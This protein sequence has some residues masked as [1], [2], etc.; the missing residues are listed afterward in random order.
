MSRASRLKRFLL[1][2]QTAWSIV[3][4]TLLLILAVELSL[5]GC[6]WL[7]DLRGP[8][9]PPD[10]RLVAEGY[11]GATWPATHY[12]E[13][14]AISDAWHPYVYFRQRPFRGETITIDSEGMRATWHPEAPTPSTSPA[15]P[16]IKVLMLGGSSLWGFGAR[17]DRTIPSLIARGLHERGVRAEIRNLAEIGYVSTQE[18]IAL[19]RELQAGY[20]PDL[21]LFYDGVNDTT[22]ALLEGRPTLTTNEINRV[23]EF[24]L[25]QSPR[26]LAAALVGNLVKNSSSFRL[27]QALGRR[28]GRGPA[29]AYPSPP[30]E[31]LHGLAEGVVKGYLG[32]I[33]LVE[34]LGRQYGFRPLFVWQPDIF[35]KSILVPFEDEEARKLDWARSMFLAVHEI[36][37]RSEVLTGA[38]DF[39]D[40]SRMFE[41][42]NSLVFL[43]YCHTTESANS[44]I[45]KVLEEAL[46]A[47]IGRARPGRGSGP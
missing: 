7:K 38:A 2:V 24:N 16:P 44:R 9:L 12:R 43:D 27:A 39:R 3:G 33:R 18:T 30:R 19:M 15:K 31:D 32:N 34:A 40:L 28:L 35:S 46:A 45:A 29:V 42:T 17:D 10:R 25:L 36:L 26:R 14:E 11:E 8:E 37:R 5:R 22:S 13:L 20:R 21:V 23:R 4:V 6:F 47:S 1:G 41:D